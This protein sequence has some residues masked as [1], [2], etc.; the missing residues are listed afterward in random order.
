MQESNQCVVKKGITT[1]E[2]SIIVPVFNAEKNIC[3]FLTHLKETVSLLSLSYEIIV[4]DDGSKDTTLRLVQREQELDAHIRILTY[5]QN[6]GKGNAVKMG[7][8]NSTGG[9]VM[10]VDGDLDI[11]PDLIIDYIREAKNCDLVIASKSHPLSKVYAPRSRRLLSKAFSLLVRISTGISIRDTQAGLK[12]AKGVPLRRI[13]ER[14]FVKRY[15]FDVE[16]LTIATVLNLK[17]KELPIDINLD[18]RFKFQEIIKM[19]I[20]VLTISY[21]Y[22]MKSWFQNQINLEPKRI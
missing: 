3:K 1:T 17:I 7:V 6:E 8:L 9:L 19:L 13:F 14:M 22:R 21:K 11:S 20:D 12:V 2:L 16:L 15:A 4:V 5:D 10:F 18:H